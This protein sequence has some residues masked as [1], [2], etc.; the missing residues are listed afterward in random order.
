[1]SDLAVTVVVGVGMSIGLIGVVVP[2]LP[3]LVLIW[4]AAL[5]YG[6]IVGF[7]AVGIAA[8]FVLTVLALAGVAAG[9]VLP[10]R[11]ATGAGASRRAQIAGVVG[12][13]IGFFVVPV[14]GL[15][16][17]ALAGLFLAEYHASRDL[18]MARVTT[19]ELARGFGVAVL[20]QFA[21]G[22]VMLLVWAL[23]ALTVLL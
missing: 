13:V 16:V 1:M 23:W 7:G 9:V 5:V 15:P 10:K 12:G 22:F 19:I 11:A 17:G 8:M 4:S 18:A 6:W 21:I 3:G 14:L 20:A 2:L